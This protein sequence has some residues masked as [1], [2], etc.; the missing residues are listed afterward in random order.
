MKVVIFGYDNGLM[1]MKEFCGFGEDD[2]IPLGLLLE[3]VTFSD[4]SQEALE[5]RLLMI[6]M[7]GN[8]RRYSRTP[9]L[10]GG[11]SG[12]QMEC[13]R[14]YGGLWTDSR[15]RVHRVQLK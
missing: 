12:L 9:M 15:R 6:D 14:V 2:M 8:L 4:G 11:A 7:R 13:D 1:V 3:L 10:D 5:L